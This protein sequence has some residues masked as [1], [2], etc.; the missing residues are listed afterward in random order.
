MW[1]MPA[2]TFE[3]I[4]IEPPAVLG[5]EL[6]CQPP[7]FFLSDARFGQAHRLSTYFRFDEGWT[8]TEGGVLKDSL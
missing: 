6:V 1:A 7:V 3:R 8:D 4:F 5:L 2:L